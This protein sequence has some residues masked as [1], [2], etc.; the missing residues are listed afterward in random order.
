MNRSEPEAR[1]CIEV[2]VS[3]PAVAWRCAWCHMLGGPS[4]T[5]QEALVTQPGAAVTW[6]AGL[7]GDS[8]H[9]GVLDVLQI[10]SSF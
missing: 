8:C 5:C 2:V 9:L 10:E 6:S 4:S 7:L 1:R 3:W